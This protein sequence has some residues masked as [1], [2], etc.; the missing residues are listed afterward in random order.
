M[1]ENRKNYFFW[2]KATFEKAAQDTVCPVCPYADERDVCRVPDPRGCALFRYL[3]ELVRLAQQLS[4]PDPRAYAD[5]IQENIKM[6]CGHVGPGACRWH[7]TLECDLQSLLPHVLE[8]VWR[9][10]AELE[11]RRGFEE[12][13]VGERVMSG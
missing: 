11:E 8:A 6:E 5:L 3:P 12:G 9:A 13:R 7:D 10:D 1:S 4:Y 2:N